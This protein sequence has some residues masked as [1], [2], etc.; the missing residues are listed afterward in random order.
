MT[1]KERRFDR[2]LNRIAGVKVGDTER[3]RRWVWRFYET[4]YATMDDRQT[5]ITEFRKEISSEH[6][7]ETVVLACDAIRH[8]WHWVDRESIVARHRV[9]GGRGNPAS[10]GRA[11]MASISGPNTTENADHGPP[12]RRQP[13]APPH[14]QD[15]G[16][17]PSRPEAAPTTK[18]WRSDVADSLIGEMRRLIRLQH[19]SFRTEKSYIGWVRRF[20]AFVQPKSSDELVQDAV[21]RYLSFLAVE[22]RVAS[23]TQ[24]QCFN[25]I[26]FLY[27]HV[28]KKDIHGLDQTIRAK[29]PRR[30]PVVLTRP[31]V[32]AIIT[33]L[34][35]P[36]DLMATVIYGAGLRLREC[37]ALRIQD[38]DFD[39]EALTVRSGKG[40][41]D[42]VSLFPQSIH[43]RMS[44][45]LADVRR[46]YDLD[47]R[48]GNPGVP[49]PY[50]LSKKLPRAW[51][52]WSWYWVFPSRRLA[53]DPRSHTVYRFHLFP[54]TLEKHFRD[55]VSVLAIPKHATVHSLRH[56]FAT[57]LI[58]DG[59]DIRTVQELLGHSSVQTTMIYTHVASKNKQ[60]VRSPLDGLP[61]TDGGWNVRESPNSPVRAHFDSRGLL[62]VRLRRIRLDE[63]RR[64]VDNGSF[65]DAG[66]QR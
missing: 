12:D 64:L 13:S 31:E 28:L 10:D 25:A 42:R 9:A 26:L 15:A 58:E 46:L 51:T 55:A 7:N 2:Y 65:G 3:Y 30:L 22:R 34:Q 24:Q 61:S 56:S 48:E 36:Y 20:L 16:G 43:A 1:E 5:A 29:R 45:H 19:K 35:S 18:E 47:R 11:K 44:E 52:E 53:E 32:T 57:H 38:L 62:V 23:S 60:G 17:A 6:D 39:A 59:Y 4:R 21:R 49:L 33:E 63:W 37:L 40:N 27:R 14:T 66:A 41:K 8:Y 50:A 54:A